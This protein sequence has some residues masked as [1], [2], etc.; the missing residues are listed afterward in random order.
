MGAVS[1]SPV[2]DL[3]L[4]DVPFDS[5]EAITLIA[6]LQQEYQIR[7]GGP[8]DTPVIATEFA[9][10]SGLFMVA[11]VGGEPVGCVGLRSH[12]VDGVECAEM[13]RMYVRSGFRRRG[14]ARRLLVAAEQRAQALGYPRLILETGTEQ[15]EALALYEKSGYRPHAGFGIYAESDGSRY[16]AKDLV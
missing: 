2:T 9:P 7:Y 3:V 12:T 8:D 5:P 4:R 6:E 11:E 1:S 13:K 15:P 14:L 10:P 16:F